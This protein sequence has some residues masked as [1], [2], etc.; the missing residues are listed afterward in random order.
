MAL[1]FDDLYQLPLSGMK[2]AVDDWAK[3]ATHLQTL[4]KEARDGM[5]AK[6]EKASWAGVNADVSRTFISKTAKE[7]DDMAKSAKG[8]AQVMS[9]GYEA[10]KKAQ[11]DLKKVVDE[12]APA[13]RVT[14]SATGTVRASKPLADNVDV[15][16]KH[17]PDY[18]LLVRKEQR[19]I[20]YIEDRIRVLV[21]AAD[22]ADQDVAKTLRANLGDDPYQADA[23]KYGST[24]EM[25]AAR[26]VEIATKGDGATDAELKELDRLVHDFRNSPDFTTTFYQGLG[27]ERSV[28]FFADL[29]L[30]SE[31]D[32]KT[33]I[34]AVQ[35]LQKDLGFALATATDPDHKPHLSEKWQTDLRKVGSSLVDVDTGRRAN[36]RPYGYQ[37]LS[38][39][40][41]YGE[42][43]R[44]FLTPI[45]EH[46]A[47][48]QAADPDIWK[49]SVPQNEP[50]IGL[51]LNPTGQGG[52][53]G[54]NAMTGILEGLGHSPEASK[55]FFD[56]KMT[57]YDR[58]GQ[59]MDKAYFERQV[60]GGY[61]TAN[62][63]NW[64][65]RVDADWNI[66]LK[67]LK[68]MDGL[69]GKTHA[70]YFDMFTDK[71]YDWFDDRS[72]TAPQIG[73]GDAQDAWDKAAEKA[74]E[75]GP[76]ALGHALESAVSGRAYDDD[77]I[78]AKP[79]PH[80]ED[81]SQLMHR[82]VEKFGSDSGSEL[83][84]IK[85]DGKSGV[86]APMNDSLG[87]MTAEYMRDF[88][89]GMGASRIETHGVDA[90]LSDLNGGPLLNFLGSI[91][92]DP[93]AYG[94]IINAQQATTTDLIN[95]VA[96][97]YVDGGKQQDFGDVRQDVATFTKPGATIA[98]I[99]TEA[100]AE[101]MYVEK[102][103]GDKDFNDG[104]KNG[105]KWADR[106]F[107]VISKPLEA[108]GVGAPLAWVVE[109]IKESVTEKYGKDSGEEADKTVNNYLED[110]RQVSALAARDAAELGAREA[111]LSVEEQKKFGD[112]AE[113]AANAGSHEGTSRGG[114]YNPPPKSKG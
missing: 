93:D 42:Y 96:D 74:K 55:D 67:D 15:A 88:Q 45:A 24:G 66:Y 64:N 39:I 85:P 33:R 52:G 87:N 71:D 100:R 54:F 81:Q 80:S 68:P 27:P 97:K 3:M 105:A 108:T 12:E 102:T 53:S 72:E 92:K 30:N 98:G 40:L 9:E 106:G 61:S 63:D 32:S 69:D 89:K 60:G 1:S 13:R 95:G 8:L 110:R 91:G 113:D 99:V 78:G 38:N 77:T 25:N 36:Y 7:F 17:D 18:Q 21:E 47:Q 37:V 48:L 50:Y 10:F 35:G 114:G 62:L 41:R 2:S 107:G 104:L 49:R 29:T 82:V 112:D 58:D 43:D 86:L 94:A 51:S 103:A 84:A 79:I 11:D 4:A 23:P 28:E 16:G 31:G 56:G 46:A 20:A 83:I 6:S 76:D 34:A 26:A 59:K 109:D 101:A 22:Q 19:D 5:R 90:G 70:D 75:S 44:R 73:D 65:L 111:G 14:V 57:P